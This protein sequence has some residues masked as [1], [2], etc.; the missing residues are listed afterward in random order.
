MFSKLNTTIANKYETITKWFTSYDAS[1]DASNDATSLHSIGNA[2]A[3][4]ELVD[5]LEPHYEL[6]RGDVFNLTFKEDDELPD[7]PLRSIS[8]YGQR[9][10]E[11]E[12]DV[13]YIILGINKTIPHRKG[14]H[15]NI[16]PNQSF[17]HFIPFGINDDQSVASYIN[18]DDMTLCQYESGLPLKHIDNIKKIKTIEE[19]N[20]PNR[21]AFN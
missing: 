16:T 17:I 14:N 2:I 3:Y 11:I 1:N 7:I 21:W 5:E 12:N 8:T 10:V 18:L 19:A 15:H 9:I 6:K 13:E 20:I 4:E